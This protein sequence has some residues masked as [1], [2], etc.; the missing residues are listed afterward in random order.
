MSQTLFDF[1]EAELNYIRAAAAEFAQANP[2]TAA[3]LRIGEGDRRDPHVERLIEAFAFLTARVQR[4]LNDQLPELTDALL[5]SLYPQYLAPVPSCIIVKFTLNESQ[6]ELAAGVDI[7]A[8]SKLES[9]PIGGHRLRFRTGYPV[10]SLPI[11]ISSATV[12][13]LTRANSALAEL[14]LTIRALSPEMPI[15]NLALD[16]LRICLAHDE[17]M[18]RRLYELVLA[19]TVDVAISSDSD[20]PNPIE[21]GTGCLAPL[22]LEPDDGLLPLPADAQPGYRLL[23]EYAAFPN[24]FLFFQLKN[25]P[26][27]CFDRFKGQFDLV[28]YLRRPAEMLERQVNA[29]HFALGCTP[30][31]NLFEGRAEPIRMDNE[32]HRVRLAPNFKPADGY[33]VYSVD[34]IMTRSS[35]GE[36]ERQYVPFHQHWKLPSDGAPAGYYHV[37]REIPLGR[38]RDGDARSEVY[39][40]LVDLSL[41]PAPDPDTTLHATLTCLNADL[42]ARFGGVGKLQLASGGALGVA[43]LGAPTRTLRRGYRNANRWR[44]ISHLMLN[45]FSLGGSGSDALRQV[46]RL[47]AGEESEHMRTAADGL[48]GVITSADVARVADGPAGLCRG[49]EIR[50]TVDKSRF[51]DGAPF[52]LGSILERF[53]ALFC[54]VNSFTRFSLR[55]A[56]DD[57]LIKQWPPRAGTQWLI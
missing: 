22:G 43:A 42:P 47:Y 11:Q 25:F 41:N 48:V 6:A 40:S 2:E 32:Q 51:P 1:Y 7:P 44:L 4:K 36:A 46:L 16:P 17:A 56:G 45:H 53:C 39:V 15:R 8:G 9:D 20:D 50:A 28:F 5:D 34:S 35:R 30:A 13:P 23:S 33:E 18:G 26:R 10:R 31:I 55:T 38:E 19:D 24:R 3:N 52:L 27:G 14:R 37:S 57:R 54:S 21:L 29:S 12:R 49:T